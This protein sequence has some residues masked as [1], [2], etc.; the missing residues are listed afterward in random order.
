MRSTPWAAPARRTTRTPKP[1]AST[2]RSSWAPT[3]PPWPLGSRSWRRRRALSPC[4]RGPRCRR[5]ARRQVDRH[6]ADAAIVRVPV[7]PHEVRVAKTGFMPFVG[8]VDVQPD[9]KAVVD[10][11]ALT[12]QPTR[13]H[14]I[15]HAP[16]SEPLRVVIDGIDLGATPWEGDL[17]AGSHDIAGRSSSATAASQT[18]NVAVGD[19][20]TVDL[21]SSATAAHLQV[22]SS[23]G[24]GHVYV[25]GVAQGRGQL[26][27]RRGPGLS[28]RGRGERRL[29]ALREDRLRSASA[30][31]GPRTVSLKTAVAAAST[32]APDS[33]YEGLYGGFGFAGLFG[34]GSTGTGPRRELQRSRRDVVRHR[35]SGRRWRLRVRRMD[36]RPRGLRGHGR[37]SRGVALGDRALHDAGSERVVAARAAA[38]RTRSSP[39]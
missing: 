17:P 37:G 36:V 14:V 15:V 22:R 20:I 33:A 27:G 18:G 34:V 12:A 8:Q 23:D 3:R 9:G 19:N 25:D 32:K 16:G 10:A 31:R 6:V 13:G 29:R 39:R 35:P 26:R 2:E 30:R 11:T 7:G 24:K 38:A 5:R 4:S 28:Y 21:V 1:S